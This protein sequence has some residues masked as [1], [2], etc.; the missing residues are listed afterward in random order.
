MGFDINEVITG[1]VGAVKDTVNVNWH[2]VKDIATTFL[3][4]KKD[5]IALL[6]T[7]RLNDEID[8][9]FFERRVKEE[10]KILESELLSLKI[11]SAAIAQKAANAALDVLSSSVQAALKIV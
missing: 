1:M 7:L 2:E 9:A 6:A 8:Q 3:E 10:E 11:V 4:N 5:R